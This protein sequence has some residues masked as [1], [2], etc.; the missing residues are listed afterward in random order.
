MWSEKKQVD[1]FIFLK[2]IDIVLMRTKFLNRLDLTFNH[3]F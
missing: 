1:Q 3:T 2:V